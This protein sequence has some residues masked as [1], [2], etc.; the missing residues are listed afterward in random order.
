VQ[1]GSKSAVYIAYQMET[2]PVTL[3]VTPDSVAVASGGVCRF[4]EGEFQLPHG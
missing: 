2:G 1:V 3:M 4:Q